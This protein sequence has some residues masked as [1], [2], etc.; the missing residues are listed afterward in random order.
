MK[1]K[2]YIKPD[3]QVY[4][5]EH[6]QLLIESRLGDKPADNNEESF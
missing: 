1:K 6:Q 4:E 2:D 5:I 3:M